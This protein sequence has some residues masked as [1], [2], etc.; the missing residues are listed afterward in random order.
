VLALPVPP[1][2]VANTAAIPVT[3]GHVVT[4]V[5]TPPERPSL[6]ER[7]TAEIDARYALHRIRACMGEQIEY[8][9]DSSG[10]VFVRA[11]VDTDARKQELQQALEGIPWL[12]TR[13][14]TIQ[15]SVNEAHARSFREN[16]SVASP[17]LSHATLVIPNDVPRDRFL[18]ISR[19]AVAD[20]ALCM[21]HAWAM[22]R[23]WDG[24]PAA[25]IALLPPESQRE[26]RAMLTDHAS[27]WR[28]VLASLQNRVAPIL[29]AQRLPPAS[30]PSEP[31]ID[32][33][34]QA[35][36]LDRLTR[37]LFSEYNGPVIDA[38]T[39]V[40]AFHSLLVQIEATLDRQK[41]VH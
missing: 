21:Q 20:S 6:L 5:A 1:S 41:P 29:N 16:L 8:T 30:A 12:H 10:Y 39:A 11:L 15:E 36:E 3:P 38:A 14:R 18:E 40:P 35:K 31:A 22:R 4:H 17:Q 32:L 37:A 13:I 7:E 33:F 27:E 34:A 26:L 19:D 28:Q 23:L 24:Y 9:A 25:R 2:V